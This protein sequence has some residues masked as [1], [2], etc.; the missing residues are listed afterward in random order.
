[1]RA[2]RGRRQSGGGAA[3][4]GWPRREPGAVGREGA[5]GRAGGRWGGEA[6]GGAAAGTGRAAACRGGRH[7]AAFLP[8]PLPPGS[9]PPDAP[10]AARGEPGAEG[11]GRTPPAKGPQAGQRGA[12]GTAVPDSPGRDP[13][14]PPPP[15]PSPGRGRPCPS[16]LPPGAAGR[17]ARVAPSPYLSL[18]V[19]LLLLGAAGPG[20]SC[21]SRWERSGSAATATIKQAMASLAASPT[22]ERGWGA[23]GPGRHP[24][25]PHGERGSGGARGAPLRGWGGSRQP[26]PPPS[27]SAGAGEGR[28][29][30]SEGT[31]VR[32]GDP[33]ESALQRCRL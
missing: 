29:G 10:S 15:A 31:G 12:G 6:G 14:A 1:M 23:A 33:R 4:Q 2:A 28:K 9:P 7:R 21:L 24:A 17:T 30:R 22:A 25:R 5:P 20:H 3:G 27:P 8:R 11:A 19:W 13:P 26:Q 16:P 18:C 32:N